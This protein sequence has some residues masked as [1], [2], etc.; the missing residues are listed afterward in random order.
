MKVISVFNQKGGVG[1]TT[2]SLNLATYISIENGMK[3]LFIDNDGQA[4]SSYILSDG[5][6]D[7]YFSSNDIPTIEELYLSKKD[8]NK[9][10]VKSKFK[11]IDYI[12]SSID[13]VYTDLNLKNN[14]TDIIKSK[15]DNLTED[16]DF[17]I[18][19]NPPAMSNT[20]LNCLN[21]SDMI[22]APIETCVFSMRGLINLI[23][24]TSDLNK[25]HVTKFF[26]FLSKVD[27][28]KITKNMEVKGILKSNLG[29]SFINKLQVSSLSAYP[30]T[31]DKFETVITSKINNRAF[32]EIKY[33]SEYIIGRV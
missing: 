22:L 16:Y 33:L 15:L 21:I 20:V 23:N 25:D 24:L 3:V 26:C 1:K 29:P 12:A 32:D 5:K 17:I 14:R 9:F 19:D 13:H 28:R 7:D 6:N 30:N 4:N 10:I 11:N 27:N 8:I 31:I 2:F 18:I